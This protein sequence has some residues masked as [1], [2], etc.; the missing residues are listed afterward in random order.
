MRTL[1][2]AALLATSATAAPPDP[3]AARVA[4]ILKATPLIDGH[5]DW[6][7]TLTGDAKDERWTL[8]LRS[9]LDKRTHPYMTDIARLRQGMVGGQFWSVFV[10]ANQPELDQVKQTLDQIDLVR[11]IVARYPETF[12]LARTAA[13]VRRIHKAG[14]IASM[15]G[16]EGGGQIDA[17]FSVLRAYHELGAGYLTLAHFKTIAWAD[18]AT[19]APTHGGLTPFGIAV[20]HELNRLGM[21][22]DL[23]HVSEGTMRAALAASKAP[24]IFSHSSA[25]ALSDH[26]RNVS[27]EVLKLLAANGGVV[28]VNFYPAYDSE[29]LRLWNAEK[30]G[31]DAKYKA[32]DIGQ[33]DKAKADLADWVKAHPAP[34]VTLSL[35]AD[36]I[37]HV[38]KVA[39]YDHVGLGSDFDGIESVPEGLEDVSK[40]PALLE[41]LMK[42]GWSDQN[43][44]K[45][46]GE[47]VLRVMAEA[48]KV[49]A[50]MKGEP[51]ATGTEVAMDKK[52]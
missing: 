11:Q 19:D 7:E 34:R 1:I 15:M 6:P 35:V 25:R 36:H 45:L 8:D 32:L 9:G 20:V 12:E 27:D 38:A 42:R 21:L 28:M 17:D 4:R 26:P 29:P 30:A 23:A 5:N 49:A 51:A 50:G 52:P 3:Y 31:A 46:A 2:L 47:N 18:S 33:P 48:E 24:V 37:D 14:R 41:E 40:Y 43:I 44:A 13:D 22:V 39:G 16:V 10:S